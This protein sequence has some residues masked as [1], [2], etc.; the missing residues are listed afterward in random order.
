MSDPHP[1][2]SPKSHRDSESGRKRT[3]WQ[4][5]GI[6][7]TISAVVLVGGYSLVAPKIRDTT[8]LPLPTLTAGVDGAVQLVQEP[9]KKDTLKDSSQAN[10]I[11]LP[12]KS[13]ESIA[14][15]KPTPSKTM[16]TSKGPL[17]DRMKS[18]GTPGSPRADSKPAASRTPPAKAPVNARPQDRGSS[19]DDTDSDLLHGRLREVGPDRYMS[20]SGLLYTPGSAE[21]HRLEHVKRHTKDQPNR[22]GNH[23]VFDGDMEGAIKTI[24]MAYERALKKIKTTVSQEEGRTVYTVD[25][26]GRIGYAGGREGNRKNK[27]MARRVRLVLDGN[28]V[29]T[30]FPL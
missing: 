2:S 14:V 20:V 21:G 23:G 10:K 7:G 12:N 13:T 22:P 29:I 26:E 5:K 30:A 19:V 25:M 3:L 15:S 24:D 8:G 18:A 6:L 27:P 11:A 17:A 9:D 4:S 16:P 28:R 1:P